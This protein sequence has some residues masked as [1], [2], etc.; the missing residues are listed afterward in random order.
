MSRLAA[1][2]LAMLLGLAPGAAAAQNPTPTPPPPA[3]VRNAQIALRNM[4]VAQKVGQLFLIQYEGDDTSAS[5]DIADLIS[6]YKVG[7]VQ[8]KASRQNF[9]NGPDGPR[10]VL[11]LTNRLQ[12][13][14]TLP[15]SA[16]ST[17]DPATGLPAG[18]PQPAKPSNYI[19]LFI[20][21][22]QD[23]DGWPYSEISHGLT[24]LPSEMALGA[25][26]KPEL[27]EAAGRTE[28]SELTRLGINLLFGPM[29]D[30]ADAP[31]SGSPGDPGVRVF[32]GD[33]YWVG[34]FGAAMTK[35]LKS[36]SS[37][38]LAVVATRFPGLG[39]SDRNAEDEAPTVQRSMEQLRQAELAPFFAVTQP[40]SESGAVVDGLLMS[41]VR[42]RGLQGNPRAVTNPISLDQQA[43]KEFMSQ[44]E[45]ATWRA[46][47]GVTFSDA[48]GARAVRRIYETPDAPFNVRLIT[49]NA[50]RAGNDVLTL[51]AFGQTN[52]WAEQRENI[53][54]AIRSFQE[55]YLIDPAFATDVDTAVVRILAL[56][57]KLYGDRFPASATNV[58][59]DVAGAIKPNTEL[60]ASIAKES[61]TVLWPGLRDLPSALPAAPGPN[62]NIVFLTDDRQLRECAKCA[63]YPAIP[64]SALRDIALRLYG[65]RTTNQLNPA[66]VQAFSFSDLG[67]L[68]ARPAATPTPEPTVT[69][70]PRVAGST[71]TPGAPGAQAAIDA[72]NWIVVSMIDFDPKASSTV[73]IFRDFLSQRAEALR[74]K[75]IVVFAFG[76]PYHLDSTE[77]TKLTAYFALYHRTQPALEAAVRALYGEYGQGASPV[78]VS[79]ISYSIAEQTQA[80]PK[81]I[82]PLVPLGAT[83]ASTR[84]VGTPAPLSPRLNDTL[85]VRA[86]PI[87][88]RNGR[89]IPDGTPVQFILAYP[90]EGV[91][92][93]QERRVA[94]R[95]GYAE[96]NITFE[97]KGKLQIS[98]R[99]DTARQS[100]LIE[101]NISDAAG[102]V[103]VSRPT[104]FPTVT[105][106]PPP[107][108][109][110]RPT[111]TALPPRPTAT[112]PAAP[113]ARST[114]LA[115]FGLTLMI[116]SGLALAAALLW[117][118]RSP[119]ASEA[120]IARNTLWSWTTG[121]VAYVAF[122]LLAPATTL[123][124]SGWALATGIAV[125]A[126]VITLIALWRAQL[127]QTVTN[128][129]HATAGR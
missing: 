124:G 98:A 110:P 86:G 42:F 67:N 54:A 71:P 112:P 99:T 72:A 57:L 108:V 97:R 35:G 117:R 105:S 91:R 3:S 34:R 20:A 23:G 78:S 120:L 56:K 90:T 63:A 125:V 18:Q 111:E 39:A 26:W 27:A 37:G 52:A 106:E 22:A 116:L 16:A 48:L 123:A 36:G 129:T 119:T 95:N 114:L 61:V 55:R 9:A 107:T 7:G 40:D 32:G 17:S 127:G 94:S 66:R 59:L 46:A 80:D 122:G 93:P 45:L 28:G 44:K 49:Q 75:K 83:D 118:L 38:R 47:G 68:A 89:V 53:K 73:Q 102:E 41:H 24:P 15:G 101:A 92:E 8:L 33:P 50:F 51:G 76:A 14:A 104:P 29:L 70:T 88:D 79:A 103:V 2:G 65:P 69:G 96:V 82:I 30:I 13:L 12:A 43:Q 87:L 25:T 85:R 31:K 121:W 60:A 21:I 6:N 19:P 1:I 10:Q 100:D 81:Q 5:S 115:G 11:T 77:V 126:A 84:T 58:D 64:T 109:T 113:P 128:R 62:D 74:D 4:S